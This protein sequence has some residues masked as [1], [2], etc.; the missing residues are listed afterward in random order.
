MLRA[1]DP[2][3]PK[4]GEVVLRQLTRRAGVLFAV[5]LLV[6][7]VLGARLT[8]LELVA[9]PELRQL[10][11]AYHLRIMPIPAPRGEMIDRHGQLLVGNVPSFSAY[12]FDLGQPPPAA[13]L[14]LL[15]GLLHESEADI[16][17]VLQNYRGAPYLPVLLKAGLTPA[18]IS[19]LGEN[20][21]RLPGV[22]V[23]AVPLRDD[24][25]GEVGAHV[26]GYVGLVTAA[27]LKALH[28]PRVNQNTVVGQAGLEAYYQHYLQGTDGGEEVE[29]DA[30]DR[31]VKV[32]GSVPPVP[33]DTLQLTLDKGLEEAAYRALVDEMKANQAMFHSKS[34]STAGAVVVM[35]VHTGQ[36][37]AMVS[38]PAYNPND[39]ARGI[40]LKAYEALLNNPDDPFENRAIQVTAPP[41]STYKPLV[42]LAALMSGTITPATTIPSPP[43]YWYPPY[44]SNWLHADFGMVGLEQAIA[45]SDDIYFYEVGRRTGVDRIAKW[46]HLFGFGEPT[47]IDLP[48]EAAGLVPTE[49]YYRAQNGGAFYPALNYYV[50]I[51]Q[52]ANE[53]T[54]LQLVRYTAAIAS[55]G[56]VWKPYLVERILAPDGRPVKVFHPTLI[57][58]LDIPAVDWQVVQA[59]MHGVTVPGSIPGP[60]GTAGYQFVNFPLSIAG[61]TG[62]A[63]VAGHQPITY[64]ISYAPYQH[65]EIAVAATINS[66]GEG[67]NV[68]PVVRAIYDYYFHLPDPNPPFPGFA[69]PTTPPSSTPSNQGGTPPAR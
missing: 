8:E 3:Q 14:R 33:G 32:L 60:G 31:P 22:F 16:T 50:A 46:A 10:G 41:G 43:N 51:G 37:L 39:F 53:M 61:K 42:A 34:V 35:D 65:P 57:R 2:R 4:R 17:K 49:K 38:V 24:V 45:Q 55:K 23:S 26:F 6:F 15:A 11:N 56:D 18:E 59:G 66:G 19:A 20:R 9:G 69:R 13:E 64:F 27:E 48:G 54:L 25:L 28:D 12:Y 5:L 1:D 36:I 44:P 68:A 29:V 21:P 62:T 47:G 7:A 67:A 30:L 52:G 63:Q 40:S 58:H